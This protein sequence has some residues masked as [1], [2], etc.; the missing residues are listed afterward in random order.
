[1][2]E[3]IPVHVKNSHLVN[4][5]LCEIDEIAPNQ[6]TFNFLDLATG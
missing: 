5:M 1:M 6:N 2:F 4:A 3:E